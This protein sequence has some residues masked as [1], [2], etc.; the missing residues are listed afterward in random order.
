MTYTI[1][2]GTFSPQILKGLVRP[3]GFVSTVS[4]ILLIKETGGL[5][6]SVAC[7]PQSGQMFFLSR[8]SDGQFGDVPCGMLLQDGIG[9]TTM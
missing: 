2:N 9:T 8:G 1:L 3:I 6:V 4:V 7:S 5:W